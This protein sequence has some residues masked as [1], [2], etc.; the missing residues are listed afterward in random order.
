MYR[1]AKLKK[2]WT[3]LVEFFKPSGTQIRTSSRSRLARQVS[4]TRYDLGGE[5]F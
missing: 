4:Q 2:Q 1:R 3:K 5:E